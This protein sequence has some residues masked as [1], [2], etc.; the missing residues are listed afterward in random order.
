V[1]NGEGKEVDGRVEVGRTVGSGVWLHP[2]RSELERRTR[3][4]VRRNDVIHMIVAAA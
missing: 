4:R 3:K 2:G 1:G